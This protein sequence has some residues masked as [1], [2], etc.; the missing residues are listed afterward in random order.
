M[1][2]CGLK[3]NSKHYNFALEVIKKASPGIKE[4]F[5]KNGLTPQELNNRFRSYRNKIINDLN[6]FLSIYSS[7]NTET[8]IL[9]LFLEEEHGWILSNNEWKQVRKQTKEKSF[10][11]LKVYKGIKRKCGKYNEIKSNRDVA[12]EFVE[13]AASIN[14]KVEENKEEIFKK[15]EG[16]SDPNKRPSVIARE[17]ILEV[18]PELKKETYK[19]VGS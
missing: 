7:E 12:K 15:I 18:L 4:L 8:A 2:R 17:A 3:Y 5:E 16:Y 9:I 13:R 6:S 11:P 14:E 1:V 19:L 10:D